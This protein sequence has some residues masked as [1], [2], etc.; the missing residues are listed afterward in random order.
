MR[1][2]SFFS[3]GL[4]FGWIFALQ[5]RVALL[6][7][8]VDLGVVPGRYSLNTDL[9]GK[10]QKPIEFQESITSGARKRRSSSQVALNEGL[11]Y[12]L[13]KV[14]FQ[15]QNVEGKAKMFG[16]SPGVIDII[17][18]TASSILWLSVFLGITP[19]VPELHRATDHLAALIPQE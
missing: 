15:V 9:S 3:V 8:V 11:N 6:G 19:V 16:N 4:V 18:G 7:I 2:I 13:F 10:L 5:E 12:L 17:Q 1:R 14:L